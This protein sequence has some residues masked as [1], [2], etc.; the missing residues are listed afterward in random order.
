VSAYFDGFSRGVQVFPNLTFQYRCSEY[1][2]DN[3]LIAVIRKACLLQAKQSI[4][5]HNPRDRMKPITTNRNVE[6]FIIAALVIIITVAHYLTPA[7]IPI[8]HAVLQRLYYVPII[9]AAISFGLRGGLFVSLVASLV[10]LPHIF[11][12][13]QTIPGMGTNA[14][15]EVLL[16]NAIAAVTGLLAD[17]EKRHRDRLEKANLALVRSDQMKQLGEI[18]AGMAHEIRNP[19]ASLRGGIELL[20]KEGTS[21]ADRTEVSGILVPEV[22]R[23]ERTIRNFLSF[24]RP[25]QLAIQPV[26]V[27]EV[28]SEVHSL[29]NRGGYTGIVFGL[30]VQPGLPMVTA[31][32][33]QLRSIIMNLAL[34]A[35]GAIDGTGRVDI[36]V[37]RDPQHVIIDVADTGRGIDPATGDRIFE[38]FFTTRK[39]GLGLGLSIVKRAVEDHGGT[40]SY[41]SVPGKGTTFEVRL[42]A[43][44]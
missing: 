4:I 12:S 21:P 34:N 44:K 10:F 32:V 14:L 30:D 22:E 1:A 11:H 27:G 31:D 42:K 6:A 19:L 13:W 40:I 43:I 20:G 18:A 16:F 38:P 26:N 37:S 2:L 9:W 25:E 41:K 35:I 17:S 7:N 29:L 28:A 24:A 33:N 36:K 23:I 5:G 8:L 39:D 15:F 3:T